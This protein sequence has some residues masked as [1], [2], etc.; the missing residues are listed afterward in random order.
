MTDGGRT[1]GRAVAR[2]LLLCAL[3]AG[4]FLMHGSPTSAGGC[5]EPRPTGA[6]TEAPTEAWRAAADPHRQ[7]GTPAGPDNGLHAPDRPGR[8]DGLHGPDDRPNRLD[9]PD[10][11]RA[12]GGELRTTAA[13][14]SCVA[15]R[16]RDGA[17]VPAPGGAV[18]A[19]GAT[20][21]T[22]LAGPHPRPADGPRAP[23]AAGR[24]LLLL[25]GV[26]RN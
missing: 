23:P 20:Q 6:P 13:A 5:H 22:A 8:P 4:L 12:H 3:L 25:L 18:P 14:D 1:R 21:P 10:G 26:A 16:G 9:R 17:G 7:H 19:V 11:P 15:H 24:R 2:L